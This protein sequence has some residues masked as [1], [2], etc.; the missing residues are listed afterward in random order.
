MSDGA[1]AINSRTGANLSV[2]GA[3]QP[4]SGLSAPP[5]LPP[6]PQKIKAI[7]DI[8]SAL[9]EITEKEL[10]PMVAHND[11]RLLQTRETLLWMERAVANEMAELDRITTAS[12]ENEFILTEKIAQAKAV[13]QDSQTREE[14]KIDDVVCAE[15][16]VYNQLYDLVTETYAIDDTLYILSK[17]L[18][19]GRISLDTFLK[20]TR[21][22]AREQFMNRALVEKI[23]TQLGLAANVY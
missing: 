22:L 6:N 14:P 9:A 21:I 5:K 2:E 8:Q 13:I 18:D 19:K 10:Q 16:V 11:I 4:G 23:S 17:A 15:T 7:H 1:S 20:R 3:N 12:Q